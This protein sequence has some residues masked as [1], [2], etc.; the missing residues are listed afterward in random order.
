MST[1]MDD[2]LKRSREIEDIRRREQRRGRRPVD[3]ETVQLQKRLQR[4]ATE[5]LELDLDE[6]LRALKEDYKLSESQLARAKAFW[7]QSRGG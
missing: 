7:L 1:T 4:N 6:F 3:L 2:D 5:L